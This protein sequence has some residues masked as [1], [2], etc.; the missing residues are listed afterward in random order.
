MSDEISV[1]AAGETVGEAK[2]AA[3]RELEALVPDLDRDAVRFQ[4]VS[5]GERG[6]LGVGYSPARVVA[7]TPAD[8][9]GDTGRPADPASSEATL[10]KELLDRTIAALDLAARVRVEEDELE[11]VAT[12][13]GPDVGVLIGRHGQ[14]LDALQALASAL[15]RR[16]TTQPRRVVVDGGDYRERRALALTRIARQSAE[17][18]TATG[19]PVALEPMSASE[20]RVVHEALKDAPDVATSSEGV[21]P[22]RYVVVVPRPPAN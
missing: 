20:R 21:E 6:L 4:V 12:V 7:S 19:A 5:E 16:S 9:A 18:V 10:V 14:T 17:R 13:A 22:H 15:V 2:W 3:L 1:E 11:I 8:S